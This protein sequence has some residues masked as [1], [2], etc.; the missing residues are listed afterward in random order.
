MVF[1]STCAQK[2]PERKKTG[3]V[4]EISNGKVYDICITEKGACYIL[5]TSDSTG[6]QFES[7]L[8]REVSNAI[9]KQMIDSCMILRGYKKGQEDSV[10]L[11]LLKEPASSTKE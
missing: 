7:Y 9:E 4:W 2:S 3:F 8:P 6:K 11:L 5:V 10:G 1:C